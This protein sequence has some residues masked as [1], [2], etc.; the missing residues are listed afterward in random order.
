MTQQKELDYQGVYQLKK[1]SLMLID[2]EL[3]LPNGI[4]LSPDEKFPGMLQPLNQGMPDIIDMSW[5]KNGKA[6]KR[7]LFFDASNL[8]GEG[9]ADGMKVDKKGNLYFT[10]PGG[11]I[12]VS[13]KG[14]HLGTI[15]PPEIPANNW[16][17][18]EKW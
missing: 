10:G 7:D 5:M 14:E 12:V 11:I 2:D 1:G 3:R 13:P 4:A 17:G 8:P 15:T 16:L 6:I 9:G 18:R